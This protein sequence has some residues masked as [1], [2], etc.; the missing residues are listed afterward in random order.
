[1]DR[2]EEIVRRVTGECAA[3]EG[4]ELVEL[5][6][7][8]GARPV[9]QILIDRVGGVTVD[10]C[11]RV[12]RAIER[13][14]E[15]EGQGEAVYRIDVAS[16]GLDRPLRELADFRRA[17]GRRVRIEPVESEAAQEGVIRAVEDDVVRLET[18]PEE[19]ID[20]P[21]SKIR[22]ARIVIRFS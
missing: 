7:G 22:L 21:L 18:S 14:I 2:L 20:L 5:Q 10:D 1:M 8:R 13:R 9:I 16:P 6:Y 4:A 19:T 3:T 12:S 11:R 15:E 17:I